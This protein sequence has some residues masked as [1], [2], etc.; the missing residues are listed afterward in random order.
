M[1]V[2][3]TVILYFLALL[4]LSRLAAK[5]GGNDAFFVGNRQSPWMLVAFGMVGASISGLTFIGVPGWVMST[6]MTYLQMCMGFVVGYLIVAFVLLPLYYR[7]K[8]TSIYAYLN[9]RFGNVSYKTGASFF[10]FSKLLGA[11]AKFYIVCRILQACFADTF[12]VPYVVVVLLASLLIWL[13]T[14]R[15][16]IRTLV[17]TDF[18]QTLCLLVA[19]ILI[20]MKVVEMLDMN[21]SEA[22]IAVWNSPHSRIFEFS[23][24]VSKQNF[25]KQFLSGV[26]VVI[27]MTGLDQD[28]MQKNLTCKDLRSAQKDMCSYGILFLPIN[29]LFLSLGILLMFLYQNLGMPLP[30]DGDSLLSGIVLGG[31][32]GT[33]CIVLFTIGVIASAFSSADSAMTAL[34][35]SFCIDI[36]RKE[37]SEQTRKRVHL[38]MFVAFI[39]ITLAF[40]SIDSGSVMDLIYTLVSYTYGPL[41]GLF[42]FGM[43][44]K[45]KPKESYVPYIAIASPVICYVIDGVV[46]QLCGY[47]FGYEILL[48]NGLLTFVGL[49]TVSRR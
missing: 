11:A 47:K 48:F 38:F 19:L 31:E 33:A 36:L 16:G 17:W 42:A 21:F 14:H 28:M 13:Y 32:M 39:I 41:L 20:L 25:W 7:H 49:M 44:T 35:T 34:T 2:L 9:S 12:S 24:I 23:D 22:M 4:L 5:G 45:R 15:G 46:G 26:F 27:V 8:L 6:G 29:F 30:A 40:N 18:F 10:I 1:L 37:H 43:L 3:V